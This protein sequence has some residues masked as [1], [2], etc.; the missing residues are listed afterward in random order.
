MC[1]ICFWWFDIFIAYIRIQMYTFFQGKSRVVPDSGPSYRKGIFLNRMLYVICVSLQWWTLLGWRYSNSIT[2]SNGVTTALHCVVPN[3][4]SNFKFK[5]KNSL[6][7]PILQDNFWFTYIKY[8]IRFAEIHKQH[9]E[10]NPR[11]SGC[12]WALWLAPA[13]PETPRDSVQIT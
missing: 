4:N 9:S 6:L 11:N 5:F 2:L 10:K 7:L 3:S 13:L 1:Y 12:H 8:S